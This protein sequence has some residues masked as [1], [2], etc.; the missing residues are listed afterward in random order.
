MEL[1]NVKVSE[2]YKNKYRHIDEN[3]FSII[4][5]VPTRNMI[6]EVTNR[7]NHNCIFCYQQKMTTPKQDIDMNLAL[8]VLREAY[9]LGG[10]EVGFSKSGEPFLNL[11]L[12]IYIREAAKLGYE[13]IYLT[14][15][16]AKADVSRVKSA[17]EAGL[18]SIKFSINAI[19][20]SEYKFIHGVND[21]DKAY[22]NLQDVYKYREDYNKEFKIFVS[23]VETKYTLH[24]RTEI[25]N[26]F[27]PYCD[28]VLIVAAWNLGGYNPEVRTKLNTSEMDV[29]Y[30]SSRHVPCPVPFNA[31]T[32][33]ANGFLTGC[34]L[35]CQNYLAVADLNKM[36]LKEAWECDIFQNFRKQHISKEIKGLACENCIYNAMIKPVPLNDTLYSDFDRTIMFS[37]E[38]VKKRI[39]K[40]L[41]DR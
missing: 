5:P 38:P 15:N 32:I 37:D 9:D 30:D 6:L 29:D 20:A 19:N 12:D 24:Q 11:D 26:L 4:P 13:Y 7:C 21:F 33:T 27:Q 40:Y 35:E 31:L 17:V 39:E 23:Y 18:N 25:Y 2:R 14:T 41:E 36:S 22:K 28:E 16:G 10:R 8:R 34:C 3:V 1:Q